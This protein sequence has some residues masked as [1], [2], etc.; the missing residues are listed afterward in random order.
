[1][2]ERLNRFRAERERILPK[3]EEYKR[4]LEDVDARIHEEEV[5]EIL[6]IVNRVEMTPEQL[7]E[8]LG[9]KDDDK[10]PVPKSKKA[11]ASKDTKAEKEAGDRSKDD[12][13][14]SLSAE[15]ENKY[16]EDVLNEIF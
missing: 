12:A 6:G 13:T 10:K 9:V 5:T 2:F 4:K 7:A 1:M 16:T 14:E 8:F 15:K 11:E 3:Y